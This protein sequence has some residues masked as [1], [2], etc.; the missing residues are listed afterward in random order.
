LEIVQVVGVGL[1]ATILILVLKEYHP[2]IAFQIAIAAGVILILLVIGY[3]VE[4]I[5]AVTEVALDAGMEVMY[6]QVLLRIIAVAYL[7]EFAAQVCRDAGEGSI[8]SKI[9]LAAKVIILV[10]AVP[11]ITSVM[12]SIL[13]L[14]PYR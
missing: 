2:E 4:I 5:Q 7:A 1:V 14:L 13:S 6:L 9:E 11:I 10:M 8:A 3:I 12:E